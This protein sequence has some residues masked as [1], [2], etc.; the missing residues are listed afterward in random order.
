MPIRLSIIFAA[1]LSIQLLFAGN[2]DKLISARSSA[3]IN[4][5]PGVLISYDTKT[6]ELARVR[7]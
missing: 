4:T 1:F 3:D 5:R 2:T 7:Q 6:K